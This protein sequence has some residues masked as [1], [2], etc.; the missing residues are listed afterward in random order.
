MKKRMKIFLAKVCS[1]ALTVALLIPS[2]GGISVSEAARKPKLSKKTVKVTVGKTVKIKVKGKKIKK[3]VWRI[4]NK[5]IAKLSA[6]KKTSVK[7]KGVAAGTTKIT[8]KVKTKGKIYVLKAVVRVKNQTENKTENSEVTDAVWSEA[9]TDAVSAEESAAEETKTQTPVATAS[10]TQ[11][12]TTT[13][14]VTQKPTETASLTQKPAATASLTQKP[15]V[16]VAPTQT[17]LSTAQEISTENPSADVSSTSVPSANT[18]A[19][20]VSATAVAEASATSIPTST[21]VKT[22]INSE[23]AAQEDNQ[24]YTEDF[25]NGKGAWYARGGSTTAVSVSTESHTGNGALLIS[26][27]TKSW[28]SP[29]IDLMDKM[30]PGGKYRFR[31]WAKV[32]DADTANAEGINLKMSIAYQTSKDSDMQYTNIPTGKVQKILQTDWTQIDEEF[33][34]PA[35]LYSLVFYIETDGSETAQYLIDDVEITCLSVPDT[36]DS[37]LESIKEVYA[38]Y[39]PN[40]GVATSYAELLNENSLSFIKHHFNSITMGNSMKLDAVMT[41][42]TM[43]LSDKAASEYVVDEDYAACDDNKD[44]DGNVIVPVLDF[45]EMDKVLALAQ[46]NGLKVR[47]HSPFWHQQNP[48]QFFTKQYERGNSAEYTDEATMY[49]REAM[50]TKTLIHHIALSGY[51]DVVYAYDVVNEYI[52]MKNEG[53]AYTNYWKYIFGDEMKTDCRY[54]KKAFASAYEALEENNLDISLIYNDYNTYYNTDKVI[55][56]INN[57]NKKDDLNPEGKTLCAGI[58]MQ[59]HIND[60]STTAERFANAIAAFAEQGFEIQITEL[61]ITN[62]GTVTADTSDEE[63]ASVWAANAKMYGEIM[64]AILNQK[65]AGANI[66][67][68]TI[69]GTTDAASWR[70]SQAPLLFGDSV[71]DKKPSFDAVISAAKNFES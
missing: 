9:P 18:L 55:E 28:N 57:I 50:Y 7:I 61:D 41:E 56:L 49:A 45:T 65:K 35:S 21:P 48:Q 12:P 6:R 54:V 17:P 62:T 15:A 10:L 59:S 63:K 27:R 4:K 69:W 11:T 1:A 32:P 34:L 13:A 66:T 47:V 40:F 5:K 26:G 33:T 71:A 67:S 52:N 68:V 38:A 70:S 16:T 53:G 39:I 14:S 30:T 44:A 37:T 24:D 22:E 46:E 19:P 43:K 60:T 2:A 29:G 20:E 58:G 8:A 36:Y 64:T 51:S 23:D 25:E 31:L 3:T 42:S